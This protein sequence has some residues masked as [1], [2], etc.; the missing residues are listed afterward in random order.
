[1]E[2]T[3][4]KTM[5]LNHETALRLWNKRFGKKIKAFDFA[6][7]EIA[8]SAYND[9]NSN[10]GWNVDHILPESKGG[11]TADYN[12]EIVHI[13]TNDEKADKFPG[14]VANGKNFTIVKVENHF[15]IKLVQNSQK[16]KEN[17]E[18]IPQENKGNQAENNKNDDEEC[19][20]FDSASGLRLFDECSQIA[21]NKT[22][23]GTIQI[24][25]FSIQNS[26]IA[27]F[28][29]E[30]FSGENVSFD[31]SERSFA[32]PNS[33]KIVVRD[34]YLPTKDLIDNLLEKCV[35]LNTYLKY[36]FIPT[37]IIKDYSM[38]FQVDVFQNKDDFLFNFNPNKLNYFQG[39]VYNASFN[40]AK[41]KINN[42]VI[43]NST[44]SKEF[45]TEKLQSN[46]YYDYDFIYPKLK[47]NLTKEVDRK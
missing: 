18:D 46:Q 17:S 10:F 29:E 20:F 23:V 42:L 1:M 19:N 3:N 7:R 41:F 38:K 5:D 28:I 11:V 31:R 25:L 9:R 2:K 8:K 21:N 43:L 12:L 45:D 6:G 37:K 16:K 27:Y 13:K 15:E 22:F 26:A 24:E 39:Y 47:D 30:L 40:Q 44:A 14:F 36:Y 4:L 32:F 34:T 35:L 33:I